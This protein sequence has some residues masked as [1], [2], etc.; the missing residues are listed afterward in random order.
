MIAGN[1]GV[2][3]GAA[4][5]RYENVSVETVNSDTSDTIVDDSDSRDPFAG[6]E[7]A[8]KNSEVI[9]IRKNVSSLKPQL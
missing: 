7:E 2:N 3:I 1:Q 6:F 5:H 4:G 9:R 8:I